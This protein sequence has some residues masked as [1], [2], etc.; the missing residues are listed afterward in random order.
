MDHLAPRDCTRRS[1]S[2]L[3]S[4]L[5]I[6]RR[7][8]CWNAPRADAPTSGCSIAAAAPATTSNCLAQYGR[9]FGFDLTASG[10]RIGKQSG[11]TRLARAS[12]AAVPFPDAHLRY[13]HFVR[14][15]VFPSRAG[16]TGGGS[17]NVPGDPPWRLAGD[18]RR[19]HGDAARRPLGSQPRGAPLQPGEPLAA[20]D[21]R[22]FHT[23]IAS[24]TPTPSSFRRWRSP[25]PSNGGAGC[26][27]K[28]DADQEITC[29]PRRSISLLTAALKVESL[30]LRAFDNPFGS[31]LLCLA[32]KSG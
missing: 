5:S 32:R 20:A 16:R 26:R 25:A 31:S 15:P 7:A 23:S 17:R 9:A 24:P 10:L 21:R 1:A 6:L 29:R 27:P 8:R 3:V 18:Q 11:R 28:Q 2:L 12:V 19:G 22:W 4:G 30:W 13:R 14:C